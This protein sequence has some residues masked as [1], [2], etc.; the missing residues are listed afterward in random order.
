ML[1]LSKKL[2]ALVF[3]HIVR[4]KLA[5]PDND[6][7]IMDCPLCGELLQ[8]Y[9]ANGWLHLVDGDADCWGVLGYGKGPSPNND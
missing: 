5:K 2:R 6:S 8:Y 3:V 4:P 1:E 9:E 7:R